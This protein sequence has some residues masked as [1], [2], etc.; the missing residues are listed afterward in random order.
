MKTIV[1]KDLNE[2]SSKCFNFIDEELNKTSDK[3]NIALTGGRFGKF[4]VSQF[5][6]KD[7]PFNKCRFFQTDER[8]VLFEDKECIQ[9]MLLQ[10][11]SLLANLETCFFDLNKSA[12]LCGK[13]MSEKIQKLDID[14]LD[15]AI[16]S[17][18]EDGHLAGNFYNST[19][20]NKKITYTDDSPKPPKSRISFSV[21]WLAQSK[22][23][24]IVAIGI[25]KIEAI[26]KL[27]SGKGL[28][29][30]LLAKSGNIFLITDQQL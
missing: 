8:L 17:L 24:I 30:N 12:I 14:R 13:N 16:M 15:I 28:F 4:F 19:K 18:G 9:R 3:L 22:L 7:A 6:K 23:V 25:E 29:S 2:A 1:V 5:S 21:E 11:L 20:I 10:E 26:K 27:S